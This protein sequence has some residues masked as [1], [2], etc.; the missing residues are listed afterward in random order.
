MSRNTVSFRKIQNA[1]QKERAEDARALRSGK[2]SPRKLQETNSFIPVGA[3]IKIVD[4]VGYVKNR[5][6]R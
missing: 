5:R 2:T 6:V 4:L 3:T 1:H